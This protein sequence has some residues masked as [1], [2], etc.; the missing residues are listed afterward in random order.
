M[1]ASVCDQLHD[2]VQNAIEAG[3]S[4]IGLQW[5]VSGGWQE[6]TVEDD[7]CG[8]DAATVE[9]ALDPFYTDGKKHRHRKVGLG[10]AFLKQMVEETGG[11]WALTSEVGRGTR[12]SFRLDQGHMDVPPAGDVV[13]SIVGLMAF[14]GNYELE[15]LR[16]VEDIQYRV[17]RTALR[18]ALGDLETGTSLELMREYVASQEEALQKG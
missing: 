17:S 15:I 10:L 6:I 8:M 3:A 18:E 7:G 4:R 13:G 5:L 11:S 12:V 16:R 1:H 2:L 9:R 14:E